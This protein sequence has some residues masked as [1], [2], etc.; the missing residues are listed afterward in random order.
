LRSFRHIGQISAASLLCALVFGGSAAAQTVLGSGDGSD[1]D[2]FRLKP[3]VYPAVPIDP[4][5]ADFGGLREPYDPYFNIDWSVALRGAYTRTGDGEQFDVIVAPSVSLE[6]TGSRSQIGLDASAE[7]DQPVDGQINVSGLRL[8][9]SSGYHLDKVTTLNANADLSISRDRPGTPGVASDIVEAPQTIV[10]N[11]DGGVTRQFGRF[12]VGVTGVIERSVYGQ[13]TLVGGLVSDNSEQDYWSLG[14]G[15]RVGFQATPIF[16]VFTEAKLGREMFDHPSSVLLVKPDA[17]NHS[18]MAG[19][20]GRWSSVLTAEASVGVNLRRFD[21]ASLGE[22]TSQLYDAKLVF[23]P[24]PT[25]RFVAGLSTK[26]AP[27]G[28]D[29]GGTTRVE[30]D[31]N[32]EAQYTVNSWL[33]LRAMADWN[34]ARFEGSNQTESGYGYG[35]GADYTLNAHTALT[36]DYGYAHADSRTGGPQ[37][38]HRVTVGVTVSR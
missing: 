32:A 30:Y 29:A 25:W 22:V 13:T 1:T 7:V 5:P 31:A 26:V 18:I 15:L 17:T 4:L 33:L 23:T 12:N 37:D 36:A 20:A 3:G 24:D 16:E 6:H 2:N 28:P 35:L 38:S 27:P 10:G 11:V 9:L 14:S 21:E 8:G 34:S 19:V